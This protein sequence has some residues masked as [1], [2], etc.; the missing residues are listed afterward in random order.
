V[1]GAAADHRPVLTEQI[2]G[3]DVLQ[4]DG[5]AGFEIPIGGRGGQ[6]V[7]QSQ[8]LHGLRRGGRC[9]LFAAADDAA[10]KDVALE[11]HSSLES[12]GEKAG[13]RR[14]A[15]RHRAGDQVDDRFTSLHATRVR[16]LPQKAA[17]LVRRRLTQ[18]LTTPDRWGRPGA[19]PR[20]P[21]FRRGRLP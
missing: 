4:G 21:G 6:A 9:H 1:A 3:H 10:P 7:S 17:Q 8:L 14:L 2:P 16:A 12:C 19:V 11:M 13:N 15:G 5:E 20:D 18:V